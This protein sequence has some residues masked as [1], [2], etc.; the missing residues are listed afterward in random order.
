MPET[1][2]TTP[3]ANGGKEAPLRTS[4]GARAREDDALQELRRLL[5]LPEHEQTSPLLKTRLRARYKALEQQAKPL[6]WGLGVLLL[7]LLVWSLFEFLDARRWRDYLGRLDAEPGVVVTEARRDGGDWFIRGL[8]DPLAADPQAILRQAGAAG[9]EVRARWEP[10]QALA[11]AI[12][13]RRAQRLLAAPRGVTFRLEDGVLYASGTAPDAWAEQARQRAGFLAGVEAYDDEALESAERRRLRTLAGAIEG[14]RLLFA[15]NSNALAPDQERALATLTDSL[16]VLQEVAA[17]LDVR[18]Q[19]RVLGHASPEGP[20]SVNQRISQ[21]RAETVRRALL[22]QG[23]PAG[24][25]EAMGTGM[26]PGSAEPSDEVQSR[27]VT[28]EVTLEG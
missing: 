20:E 10:Y 21:R 17:E 27:S 28:F 24:R 2:S 12:I 22:E 14:H 4:G 25:A 15:K 5:L 6:L 1:L 7:L 16:A 19:L 23:V 13:A 11:P 18:W 8:R 3:G 26:P 9:K